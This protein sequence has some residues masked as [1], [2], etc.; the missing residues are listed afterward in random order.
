MFLRLRGGNLTISRSP[1]VTRDGQNLL[2]VPNK[3]KFRSAR[4]DPIH[5]TNALTVPKIPDFDC[6]H[7]FNASGSFIVRVADFFCVDPTNSPPGP[8]SFSASPEQN[9]LLVHYSRR[10]PMHLCSPP[11]ALQCLHASMSASPTSS[12]PPGTPPPSSI[13][14]AASSLASS[15]PP[16]SSSISPRTR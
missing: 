5:F 13:T 2:M 10:Y 12:I 16:P 11:P 3:L 9:Q 1:V 7:E 15:P 6:L 8:G 4:V 14:K